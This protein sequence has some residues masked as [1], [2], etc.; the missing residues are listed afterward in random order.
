ML[1][2]AYQKEMCKF[3]RE[4]VLPAWDGLITRQQGQ[5]EA[6]GVPNMFVTSDP[7][8]TEVRFINRRL[9]T[10]T[11]AIPLSFLS[12]LPMGLAQPQRQKQI[13]NVLLG[14]VGNG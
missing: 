4:R 1:Q 8:D 5:L 7:R 2:D 10:P 6:L 14:L 9:H 3:D 13:I 12:A 11:N